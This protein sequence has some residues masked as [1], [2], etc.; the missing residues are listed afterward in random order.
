MRLGDSCGDRDDGSL[1]ATASFLLLSH[2]AKLDALRAE[3]RE[4]ELNVAGRK[5]SYQE[6]KELR[7]S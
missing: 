2:P 4:A 3:I 7:I 5:L 1:L 6:L